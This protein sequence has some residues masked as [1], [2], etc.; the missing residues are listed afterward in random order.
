MD[1]LVGNGEVL[2]ALNEVNRTWTSPPRLKWSER[3]YSPPIVGATK[4][5]GTVVEELK[6][7]D[8]TTDDCVG[9]APRAISV[10]IMIR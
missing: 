3:K 10:P 5:P 1:V 8:G 7:L 2:V 4:N 9:R 6:E